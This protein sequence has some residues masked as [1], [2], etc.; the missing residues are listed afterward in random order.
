MYLYEAFD[1]KAAKDKAAD[2]SILGAN[3][4]Q[5]V[6][7]VERLECHATNTNDPGEDYCEW[8]A[9]DKDGNWLGARKVPGY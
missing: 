5:V 9:F 8:R 3:M 7:Q 2:T 1:G 6:E 4:P